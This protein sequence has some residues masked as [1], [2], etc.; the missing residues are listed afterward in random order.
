MPKYFLHLRIDGRLMP[1]DEGTL[2]PDLETAKREAI[3]G[4]RDLVAG[5]VR[6]GEPLDL[7]WAFE[8][9]DDTGRTVLVVPFS[10]AIS[11]RK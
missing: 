11:L 7:S 9:A 1:D 5:R 2:L 6:D 4:A 10:E 8:I 3:E